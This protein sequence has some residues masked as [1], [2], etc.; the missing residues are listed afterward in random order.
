MR[1]ASLRPVLALAATLSLALLGGCAGTG[2]G[3]SGRSPD[4]I[5]EEEILESASNNAYELVERQRPNW[6]RG[7]GAASMSDPGSQYPVVYIGNVRHGEVESL[8]GIPS[9]SIIEIRFIRAADATTRF[10]S[11]HAGGVIQIQMRS[12]E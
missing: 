8:R 6:L 9:R 10:G 12:G 2:E 7:R 11:G 4:R 1:A 5:G 3:S